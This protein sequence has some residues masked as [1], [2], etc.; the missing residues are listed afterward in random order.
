[1]KLKLMFV[2]NVDWFFLSHRLPI[3]LEALR[4]GYKVH[5]ATVLTDKAKVLQDYGFVIHPLS[6]HRSRASLGAAIYEFWQIYRL[7]KDVRPDIVHLVT[8]KPLLF[9]GL[10]ARF[11]SL[12]AVVSA[13]SGLGLVFVTK[14]LRATIRRW[15]VSKLYRFALN[16]HNQK[17]IFQNPDD[18]TCLVKVAHLCNEKVTIVRGSG[19]DLNEYCVMP[20]PT[21]VP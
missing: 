15:L 18:L 3:A 2:V 11:A 8:I 7:F 14:G 17:V 5:I 6:L 20:F 10:A 1:M 21:G 13:V 19:V 12:P 9:G 16:H 4:N